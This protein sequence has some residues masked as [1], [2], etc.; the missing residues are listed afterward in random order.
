M[1]SVPEPVTV[2]DEVAA[3][4][5]YDADRLLLDHHHHGVVIKHAMEDL[6]QLVRNGLLLA[7]LPSLPSAAI[8]APDGLIVKTDDGI[9]SRLDIARVCRNMLL[10]IEQGLLGLDSELG[11]TRSSD[12]VIDITD[13]QVVDFLLVTLPIMTEAFLKR[14]TRG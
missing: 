2:I 5:D 12:S 13:S 4:R 7:L 14:R 11:S 8:D 6:S 9:F 3:Y 1:L 10:V